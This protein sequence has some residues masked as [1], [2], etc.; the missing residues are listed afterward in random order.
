MKNTLKIIYVYMYN[1]I[2]LMCT[3]NIV[4]QLCFI[5][6][7]ILREKK[8]WMNLGFPGGSV[9][10]NPPSAGDTGLIADPGR[11]HMPQGS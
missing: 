3:W 8:E 9:V 11:S 5:K 1:W 2:T 6:I 10:K 7:Y 4:S